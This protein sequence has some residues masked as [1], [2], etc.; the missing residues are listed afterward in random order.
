MMKSCIDEIKEIKNLETKNFLDYTNIKGQLFNYLTCLVKER[1]DG[2]PYLKRKR[3][4]MQNCKKNRVSQAKK[5]IIDNLDTHISIEE[6]AQRLG[7]SQYKLQKGFKKVEGTTVY[8]FILKVKMDS[9]KNLLENT[10]YPIIE[11]AQKLGY[12]NPSKFSTAFRRRTGYS[13]SE[14]RELKKD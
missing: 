1:V 12:E 3:C 5:I 13:P 8:N 10:D 2:S 7:V 11:I 4:K 9:G 14:Y 6:I